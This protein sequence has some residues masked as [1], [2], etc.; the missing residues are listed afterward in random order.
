M[1]NQQETIDSSYYRVSIRTVKEGVIT[2]E[3]L[4]DAFVRSANSNKRPSVD[5]W[6]E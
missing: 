4:L 6:K 1:D 2:E 3:L 5:T